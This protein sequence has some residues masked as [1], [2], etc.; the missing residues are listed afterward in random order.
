MTIKNIANLSFLLLSIG[1]ISCNTPDDIVEANNTD[2]ALVNAL[3]E[4]SGGVGKLFYE[5]PS[6][7]NYL[8]IP[9]DPLNPLSKSKVELGQFLFHETGLGQNP[10]KELE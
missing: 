5:L 3:K 10:K 8:K 7:D 1:I 9:Q 6:S 4:S 2:L